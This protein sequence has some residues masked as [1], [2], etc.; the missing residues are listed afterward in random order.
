MSGRSGR[1]WDAVER[2]EREQARVAPDLVGRR[3]SGGT[4]L[5]EAAVDPG[6]REMPREIGEQQDHDGV[7]RAA[8]KARRHG[9]AH[10]HGGD[11]EAEEPG[12]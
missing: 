12:D 4:S 10:G 5:G 2:Q 9:V 1:F 6:A 3:L 8:Q 11:I 7:D